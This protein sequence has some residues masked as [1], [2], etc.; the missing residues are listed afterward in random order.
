M[1]KGRGKRAE[2]S[3]GSRACD[4]RIAGIRCGVLFAVALVISA[5]A[6]LFA[7]DSTGGATGSIPRAA[8]SE[9]PAADKMSLKNLIKPQ[10]LQTPFVAG[11]SAR[12]QQLQAIVDSKDWL[13]DPFRHLQTDMVDVIDDLAEG[14]THKPARVT[15][16]KIVSRLD[17]LIELLEKQCKGGGGGNP[18]SPLRRSVLAGGPGGVGDLNAPRNSRRKWA[19]L[20]PKERERILQSRTEGFPAGYEEILGE[21]YRRLATEDSVRAIAPSAAKPASDKTP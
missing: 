5:T 17:V 13:K 9:R 2:G 6:V 12:L 7:G 1:R 19:E 16:P 15:E 4:P 20:T 21:Y 11:K 14:Q 10:F 8:N 3:G 18:N